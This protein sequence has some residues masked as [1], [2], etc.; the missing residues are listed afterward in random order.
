MKK[1][2]VKHALRTLSLL[3]SILMLPLG[4]FPTIGATS[5]FSGAASDY[6][7]ALIEKGFPKDYAYA[8][9]EL[10]LLHPTWDFTPLP[11]TEQ[12]A[13]YTWDHV[14]DEESK[15]PSNN[16]IFSSA[17]YAAYRHP[18]NE[19]LYDSSY[20]QVSREGLAYFMDPRNFLNETDIFQFFDLSSSAGVSE[21]AIESVL[22][23][24]FMEAAT[25]E[26]GK[27]YAQY[28]M[29][30]G[31]ELGLNPIYLAV[32]ARQEQGV[33]GTS[34]II[35]GKCGTLLDTFY[36]NGTQ[37]GESGLLVLAPT[38][39]HT[40]EELLALDGYYNLFNVGAG[41]NGVF[42][43]YYNAM[44][45]AITGTA[46]KSEEWGS[47]AWNTLWKSLYGG[48]AVIK[49][50]YVSDYKNTIYLQK[51]NVDSRASGNFWKQY[52]QNVTGAFT[53][54]RTFYT[55]FAST[56]ML[57]T[58][59]SFLIPVFGGMPELPSPDPAN[60]ECSYLAVAPLKYTHEHEITLPTLLSASNVPS[61]G[62]VN[63]NAWGFLELTCEVEHSYGVKGLEYS[64]DGGTEWVRISDTGSAAVAI[65][66]TFDEGTV[67]VLA[68]RGIADYDSTVSAK[69][70]N[71]AFL[72]AVIYVEITA[73]EPITLTLKNGDT[74]TVFSY[75]AGTPFPLPALPDVGFVGWYTQ[76]GTLLPAGATVRPTADVTYRSLILDYKQLDGAAL[77]ST[78]E[79]A[80]LRFYSALDAT[81]RALLSTLKNP[82]TL[83]ATLETESDTLLVE[84]T[85]RE[86]FEAFGKVWKMTYAD[87]APIDREHIDDVYTATFYISVTY[88]NGVTRVFDAVGT[89][90]NQ[91][92]TREVATAALADADTAYS[93][94]LI[95]ALEDLVS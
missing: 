87:T 21:A 27:T 15:D 43:I 30:V 77:I 68:L 49:K 71:S 72:C 20:Y 80:R 82:A 35:S 37:T 64:W 1:T 95:R 39:G 44:N 10:H 32:K 3:L 84:V 29:E 61:Y 5:P 46:N 7:D 31:N 94:T 54:A 57:D 50:S 75:A 13:E 38:E 33:G 63:A 24:T 62:R 76:D 9:T 59:C 42:S 90:E 47:P 70:T 19:E 14:L 25:L 23:G 22:S 92:S 55:S 36:Q 16:I 6:C 4:A 48:A 86:Q 45:R 28:F 69:K 51:F 74:E 52:M 26:N 60:G 79:G 81:S 11:I 12:K 56:G 2:Y 17:S 34:P 67:H 66:I 85:E 91:R 78:E 18:D 8:L 58:T 41:G 93:A 40:S 89:K 88:S 65:P 83:Y 73:A 53:E